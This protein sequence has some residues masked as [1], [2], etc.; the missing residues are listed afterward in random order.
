M[1]CGIKAEEYD[2]LGDL[3]EEWHKKVK[4]HILEGT[5]SAIL[6]SWLWTEHSKIMINCIY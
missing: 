5:G 2:L 4:D 3:A 6:K 1:Q